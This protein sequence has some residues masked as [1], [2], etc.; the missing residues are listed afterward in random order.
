MQAYDEGA[1]LGTLR[2]FGSI[3]QKFRGPVGTGDGSSGTGYLKNYN[4]D[5]R[6][7]YSPPPYFLDP[8]GSGWGAEDLRRGSCH[9][10]GYRC[11]VGRRGTGEL[12][13]S[14]R[15]NVPIRLKCG[16]QPPTTWV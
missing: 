10:A 1:K 5:T 11:E 15:K 12:R 4:F 7:R 13:A 14:G 2:V 3:A 16:I 6:L 9:G 8:V